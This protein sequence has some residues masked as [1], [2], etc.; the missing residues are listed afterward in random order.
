LVLRQVAFGVFLG[1]ESRSHIMNAEL[2]TF[3][4]LLRRFGQS[5]DI[6]NL[7]LDQ[8]GVCRLVFD[9]D[10]TVDI[11]PINGVDQVCLY[12]KISLVP[13]EDREAFLLDVLA[14]NLYGRDTGSASLGF[15]SAQGAILLTQRLIDS[16]CTEL[17]IFQRELLT[18]VDTTRRLSARFADWHLGATQPDSNQSYLETAP[19]EPKGIDPTGASGQQPWFRV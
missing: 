10:V 13:E 7:T 18:F 2:T 6:P 8:Y 12:T 16:Q 4:E 1:D 17:D 14:C 3:P 9:K 15:E 5:N 11:E 19:D